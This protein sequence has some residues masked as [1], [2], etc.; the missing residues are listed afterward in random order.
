LY[1]FTHPRPYPPRCTALPFHFRCFFCCRVR[2]SHAG[3]WGIPPPPA[4]L[5]CPCSRC[6]GWGI[7][8]AWIPRTLASPRSVTFFFG[9]PPVPI[10]RNWHGLRLWGPPIARV[11]ATSWTNPGNPP[12]PPSRFSWLFRDVHPRVIQPPPRRCYLRIFPRDDLTLGRPTRLTFLSTC[13]PRYVG[14]H[15][16]AGHFRLRLTSGRH[17]P[18]LACVPTHI[19]I[20]HWGHFQSL[21]P[22]HLCWCGL[23]LYTPGLVVL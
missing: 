17:L 4:Y 14:C 5:L 2:L 10:F 21:S 19:S 12:Q 1:P 18:L 23:A 8:P 3:G 22:G 6:G 13:Y 9:V 20:V 16:P 11:W 15:P 7:I